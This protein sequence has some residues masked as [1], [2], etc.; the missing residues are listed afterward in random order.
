M[1][2]TVATVLKTLLLAQPPQTHH[3]AALLVDD[4]LATAM[5]TLHSTV[6]TTLQAMGGLVFS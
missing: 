2:Q 4:A 6:S 3:Q 1:H 5:H